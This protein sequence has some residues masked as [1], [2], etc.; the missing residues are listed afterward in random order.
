MKKDFQPDYETD[1]YA[2]DN[3]PISVLFVSIT[4]IYLVLA[5]IS[6]QFIL[7]DEVYIRS[8]SDQ[9]IEA[10]LNMRERYGWLNYVFIPVTL[11]LKIS[12]PA[13]CIT[14]GT[15]LSSLEIKFKTFFKAVL[16]AEVV[17]ILAQIL[18][19]INL[20]RHLDAL[21]IEKSLNYF[22]LSVISI[23]GVEN[24]VLWLHYPLQTLNLFEVFYILIISW[25][26]SRQWKPNFIESLNIVLPSYGTGLLLW[27]VLVTFL[28][29]QIS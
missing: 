9:T 7:G 29:L 17:F 12:F 18:Y 25:L 22:P 8:F 15:V 1:S 20:S 6:D 11:F 24:V 4:A 26:L 21:T 28:T 13:L 5:Y 3:I 14:I 10:V 27:L 16:L 19:L 2:Y 23:Y